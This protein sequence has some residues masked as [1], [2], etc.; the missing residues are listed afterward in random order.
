M[1]QS[2]RIDG[3]SISL[4]NTKLRKLP[5]ISLTP[6]ESCPKGV[7]CSKDCYAVKAQRRSKHAKR[8][9]ANNLAI[10]RAA[11]D[12]Y[13]GA[14]RKF[15]KKRKPEH[16]RWHSAGDILGESYLEEMFR[17]ALETPTTKF[18]A[19]TKN[20]GV[21]PYSLYDELPD[22]LSVVLSAWP[23]YPLYNPYELPVAW[24]E[25]DERIPEGDVFHCVGH[26]DTCF[27]CWTLADIGLDVVLKKL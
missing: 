3:V 7:P 11:P 8:A 23:D 6:I 18:M 5:N 17:I 27:A 19:F 10:A 16:F 24:V 20:Y 1:S 15:L 2:V 12:V 26:C 21:L 22:S 9:W 13:F 4:G 14:I 25:G